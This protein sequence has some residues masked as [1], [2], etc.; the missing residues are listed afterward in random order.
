MTLAGVVTFAASPASNAR[1]DRD[2][3]PA[4]LYAGAGTP[5][6]V[7]AFFPGTAVYDGTGLK[8]SAYVIERGQD[9]L[10]TNLDNRTV[11]NCHKV[12]SLEEGRRGRPLFSSETVCDP[13]A[14]SL[15]RTSRLRPGTYGY[16]CA[17][18]S[19]M[20]GLVEIR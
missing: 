7:G 17:V 5:A 18:H 3:E 11:S 19:G 15:V 1:A 12:V 6:T 16:V 9:L 14:Q 20:F 8:G 13:T 10:L 2:R 4:P